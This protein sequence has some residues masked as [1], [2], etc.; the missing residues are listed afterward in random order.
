MGCCHDISKELY[1]WRTKQD[2]V[3]EESMTDWL[4]YAFEK[5]S[6]RV[7]GM[8]FTRHEENKF[9]ADWEWWVLT[10]GAAYRF[11]V[12]AKKLISG[13]SNTKLI[14]YKTSRGLQIDLLIN[15][16]KSRCALPLYAFYTTVKPSIFL[17]RLNVPWIPAAVLDMCKD[18]PNGCYLAYAPAIRSLL[19]RGSRPVLKDYRLVNTSAGLSVFDHLNEPAQNRSL[20][21]WLAYLNAYLAE[22]QQ[23]LDETI[24]GFRHLEQDYPAYLLD[25]M[26]LAYSQENIFSRENP[27]QVLE[28]KYPS[29]LKNIRGLMLTD[30]R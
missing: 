24:W 8:K 4:L 25:A 23:S 6:S 21:T 1:D 12:Q 19:T 14:K 10:N 27:A 22:Q 9:G 7:K 5:K 29:E 30:L 11:L 2:T 17:Q 26:G 16:A 20:V 3:F 15:E 28:Q 13:K 18:C